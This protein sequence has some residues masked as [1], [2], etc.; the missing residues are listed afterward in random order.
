MCQ[1]STQNRSPKLKWHVCFV[2]VYL[3]KEVHYKQQQQQRAD[4]NAKL[5]ETIHQFVALPTAAWCVSAEDVISLLTQTHMHT[6][7]VS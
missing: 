7:V 1:I 2:F 3:L 6:Q 4:L 5:A